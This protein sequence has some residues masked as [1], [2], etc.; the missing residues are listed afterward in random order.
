MNCLYLKQISWAANSSK[1]ILPQGNLS[2]P[3]TGAN[4]VWVLCKL[5]YE[6]HYARKKGICLK[7]DV[8]GVMDGEHTDKHTDTN[9]NKHTHRHSH[10][11]TNTVTHAP[12][13]MHRHTDR[14]THRQTYTQ[15]HQHTYTNTRIDTQIDTETDRHTP[16]IDR[17]TGASSSKT[18]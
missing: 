2:L 17:A 16:G 14:H 9:T 8:E 6:F 12:T 13:R 10:R 4:C 5:F 18:S 7:S 1:E 3:C 11:H 15:I